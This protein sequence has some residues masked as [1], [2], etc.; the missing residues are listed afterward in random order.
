[1]ID[2]D[3]VMAGLVP[4]ISF[5]AVTR[6]RAPSHRRPGLYHTTLAMSVCDFCDEA[7]TTPQKKC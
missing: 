6:S 4:A 2:R 1:L 5:V 3:S 7:V